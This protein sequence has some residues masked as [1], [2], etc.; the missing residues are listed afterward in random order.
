M[1]G[2]DEH[3]SRRHMVEVCVTG[4]LMMTGIVASAQQSDICTN[5]ACSGHGDCFLKDG[6]PICACHSGY[7]P[8]DSRL[9]CI[10]S[11]APVAPPTTAA[12]DLCAGVVCSNQGTCIVK[13]GAPLCACNEGYMADT[14][15]TGCIPVTGTPAPT[16]TSEQAAAVDSAETGPSDTATPSASS[17]KDQA[18]AQ[19]TEPPPGPGLAETVSDPSTAPVNQPTVHPNKKRKALISAGAALLGVGALSAMFGGVATVMAL[20]AADDYNTEFHESDKE[21]ARLWT[22]LMWGGFGAGVGLMIAGTV[23][24]VIAPNREPSPSSQSISLAPM[25]GRKAFGLS[26]SRSW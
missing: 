9:N 13:G 3:T 2:R 8:D 12:A 4:V 14:A 21:S 18:F 10:E 6:R 5:I 20:N 11:T 23:L 26:L 1:L 17:A 24:L 16:S 15:G 19:T 25:I 7:T 22:G